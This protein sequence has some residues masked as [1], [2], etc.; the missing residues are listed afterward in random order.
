MVRALL[1][2]EKGRGRVSP[3]PMVGAVI[4][5]NGGIISEGYHEY[6]GGSHAEINAIKR[7]KKSVKGARMVLNLEPCV[8]QGKTPPC[9]PEIVK[10]GIKEVTIG[11]KDPNP[12]V[13]GRGIKYLTSRGI[14]VKTGVLGKECRFLNRAFVSSFERKRPWVVL[15]E[16]LSLDG[17]IASKTGNSKWITNEKSRIFAHLLRYGSD[18]VMAGAQTLRIDKPSLKP[19]LLNKKPHPLGFPAR[20][21]LTHSGRIGG[22]AQS[23]DNS[24]ALIIATDNKNAAKKYLSTTGK[25]SVICFKSINNLLEQLCIKGYNSVLLEGGG[26]LAG[27]FFDADLIDEV[28]FIFAPVVIGGERAVSAVAGEGCR[29]VKEAVSF[30]KWEVLDADGNFI[31]HGLRN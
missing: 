19:Y 31:F 17:K 10:A 8:H 2:A 7:A 16:G 25:A 27:S 15:K 4:Y 6:F 30:K 21:V 23:V 13:K 11:M 24:E 14:K 1:L 9:V 20:C 3:N 18:V 5:N 22:C 28:Y 26:K 29:F 12:L